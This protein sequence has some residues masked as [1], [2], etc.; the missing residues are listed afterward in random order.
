M[1]LQSPTKPEGCTAI[2]LLLIH[3]DVLIL[4]GVTTG[5]LFRTIVKNGGL[6]IV[7]I[8]DKAV[9]LPFIGTLQVFITIHREIVL[10]HQKSE[11]LYARA[12]CNS[13]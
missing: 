13:N 7:V 1:L 3:P 11:Y 10:P 6:T 4:Y 8:H 2:Y 9:Y 5:N 12:D